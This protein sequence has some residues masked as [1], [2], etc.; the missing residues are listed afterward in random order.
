VE[1]GDFGLQITNQAFAESKNKTWIWTTSW[2]II[3]SSNSWSR[4]SGEEEEEEEMRSQE[5]EK[6]CWV[7]NANLTILVALRRMFLLADLLIA[8]E[9]LWTQCFIIARTFDFLT[10]PSTA[11]CNLRFKSDLFKEKI[12]DILVH[13]AGI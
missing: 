6:F 13:L 3:C 8:A 7:C 2:F 10:S 9:I 12:F 1:L 11:N 4:S 5:E